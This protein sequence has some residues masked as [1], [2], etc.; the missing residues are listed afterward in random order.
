MAED[1]KCE[2]VLRRGSRTEENLRAAFAA[3]AMAHSRYAVYSRRAGERGNQG[4]EALFAEM[5]GREQAHAELW[6]SLL[7]REPGVSGEELLAAREAA[8]YAW[9]E[10]Y[11]AYAAQAREE[12]LEE[13]A[14]LFEKAAEIEAEHE[15]RCGQLL[16]QR[17]MA[18]GDPAVET[19][20][21]LQTVEETSEMLPTGGV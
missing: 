16:E 2:A 10:L 19:V 20:E 9:S 5:A 6:L 13:I 15:R 4:E 8:N 18:E 11:A 7:E 1:R 12:G 21:P 3:G 17:G 14:N